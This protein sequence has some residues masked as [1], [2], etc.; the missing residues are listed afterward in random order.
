[1]EKYSR[2]LTKKRYFIFFCHAPSATHIPAIELP[3]LLCSHIKSNLTSKFLR[4]LFCLLVFV[5]MIP[6]CV[7]EEQIRELNM[8]TNR[9]PLGKRVQLESLLFYYTSGLS[10][11]QCSGAEG[12]ANGAKHTVSRRTLYRWVRYYEDTGM[13]MYLRP[14]VLKGRRSLTWA[15]EQYLCSLALSHPELYLDELQEKLIL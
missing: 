1:M 6:R 2:Q 10:I 14:R 5:K 8:A 13:P 9:M 4:A 15:E 11:S 7:I 3:A 12:V